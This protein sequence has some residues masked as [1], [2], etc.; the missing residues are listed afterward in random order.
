MLAELACVDYVTVFG[1]DTP[2]HLIEAIAPDVYA[3]GGDYTPSMLAET[4]VVE[5]HGGEV[6]ILDWVSPHSTSGIIAR[7]QAIGSEA[8]A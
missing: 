8:D 2:V 6:R 5:A 3:K 4:P 1:G 7:A